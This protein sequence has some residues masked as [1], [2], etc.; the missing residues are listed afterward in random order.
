MLYSVTSCMIS[1]TGALVPILLTSTLAALYLED[2][3]LGYLQ[4]VRKADHSVPCL[5]CRDVVQEGA[6]WKDDPVRQALEENW[7]GMWI[8]IRSLI[9]GISGG[10]DWGA[11]AEPFWQIGMFP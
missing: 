10:A 7:L 1:M 6:M 11:L 9:Y 8:S 3:A 2:S 4:D 5:S